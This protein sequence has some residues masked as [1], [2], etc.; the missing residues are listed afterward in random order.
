M[1]ALPEP[2]FNAAPDPDFRYTVYVLSISREKSQLGM[3][4][5][6]IIL[7]IQACFK[8]LKY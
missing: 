5:M 1:S 3:D 8:N 2:V 6:G 4:G 7:N